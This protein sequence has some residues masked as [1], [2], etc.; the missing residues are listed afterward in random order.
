MRQTKKKLG[1]YWDNRVSKIIPHNANFKKVEQEFK[2]HF[3]FIGTTIKRVLIPLAA[4]Y[5]ILGLVMDLN[6]FGSLL[7]SLL[8]FLYSNL[9][10]DMDFLIKKTERKF[11][12]SLWYEKYF[13]LLFAPITLYYVLIGRAKPAYSAEHKC[14][15]N[16]K[17]AVIYG[18]FLFLI[19]NILW[20]ERIKILMLPLFGIV[21]YFFHLIVDGIVF[22]SIS[23][24]K[25]I[26]R[27]KKVK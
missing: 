1:G 17:S 5:I 10:P 22:Q 14:F 19:G 13:W 18:I 11:K 20:D 25:K 26:K 3:G 8:V 4:F 16:I 24:K 9:I 6:V 21:G 12:E 15:H 2:E 23:L 27:I 7:L